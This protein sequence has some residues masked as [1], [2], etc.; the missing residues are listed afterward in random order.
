MIGRSD[1]L[2]RPRG[3]V[4]STSLMRLVPLTAL[5]AL[6]ALVSLLAFAPRLRELAWKASLALGLVML[7][8]GTWVALS[9]APPD[10]YMGEVQRILYVHVPILW[11]GL[12]ALLL[13]FLCSVTYLLRA[14]RAA[15]AL[16][17]ATAEVGV[18]FGLVGLGI[19]AIWGKQTWGVWWSWDPRMTATVAM[20]G[21][22]SLYLVV[23][24]VVREEQARAS[25]SAMVAL[26]VAVAPP[27][28]WFSVRWW[29][30]LH[31]LQSSPKTMDPAM[32]LALA[33]NGVA[34]LGLF[35]ALT[36]HRYLVA[37]TALERLSP[38]ARSGA[39]RAAV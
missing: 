12:F 6:L 24:A 30:S 22:Y 14:S 35:V 2:R 7:A 15:D 18:A 17:E 13:N 10:Q 20:L 8:S 37:R 28:V 21:V 25:F 34:W 9:W 27:V 31:Q 39:D 19:G 36:W 38:T 33:W 23:R 16:A 5:L 3:L 26:V 4:V 1:L 11:M 32:T 29:P